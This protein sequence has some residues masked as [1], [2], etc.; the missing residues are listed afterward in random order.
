VDGEGYLE[1]I[2]PIEWLQNQ[3]TG[4]KYTDLQQAI[5]ETENKEIIKVLQ[6]KQQS[7]SI[8]IL[9]DK[10][11]ILDLNGNTILTYGTIEIEGNLETI[12]TTNEGKI[13]SHTVD[14]V[15]KNKGAGRI[16]VSRR[17]G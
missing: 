3:S 14:A 2:E 7:I 4:K 13:E 16:K 8:M 1:K 9:G 11:I 17:N 6:N 10:D 15:M 12:D 5:D